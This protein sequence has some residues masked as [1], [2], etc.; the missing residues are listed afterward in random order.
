MPNT[1][2]RRELIIDPQQCRIGACQQ[3]LHHLG[4]D[5]IIADR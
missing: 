5:V 3:A 1:A 4:S 2:K